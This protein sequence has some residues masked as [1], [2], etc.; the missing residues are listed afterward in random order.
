MTNF[1][2]GWVI[3]GQIAALTHTASTVS[4]DEFA[5][6]IAQTSALLEDSG[7]DDLRRCVGLGSRRFRF[8]RLS[9]HPIQ[10]FLQFGDWGQ[11]FVEQQ[12]RP[13]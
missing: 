2:V 5:A 3:P 6:I 9:D 7:T 8:F 11:R 12:I 13:R 4:S 1:K 10:N